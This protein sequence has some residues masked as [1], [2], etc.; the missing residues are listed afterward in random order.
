MAELLD[1]T[2]RRTRAEIAALPARRLRV[3]GLGRHRRLHRRAGAPL[4]AGRDRARRRLV[5]PRGQRPAAAG[6][7]QL[8]VRADLLGVRLRAQVPDRPRPAGQ[9]RLLPAGPP[10]RPAR[11][12]HE[13]HL[14]LA[15]RRRLGDADPARRHHLP[16]D[17]AGAA[18][19]APGRDEGDDV[20]RG[21]RRRRPGHERVRLLPRDVRRRLRRP[22]RE[23][24]PRRRAGARPEHRERARRGDGAQLPGARRPALARRRLRRRRPLP[25]RARA[26]QGLPLRPADDVHGAVRPDEGRPGRRLRRARRAGWPSTC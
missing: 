24:R 4:R 10:R 12:R 6:A 17:P 2:E 5:R 13:L 11:Q 9:R 16:R 18:G 23:R 19:G 22:A 21:L 20:P 15:R 14:A 7:R 25:R 26:A 3:G 8:D 1:Y